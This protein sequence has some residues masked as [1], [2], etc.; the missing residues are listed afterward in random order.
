MTRAVPGRDGG[1]GRATEQAEPAPDGSSSASS[2][3]CAVS[4]SPG[5]SATVWPPRFQA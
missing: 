3:C 2:S 1:A 5:R 4:T